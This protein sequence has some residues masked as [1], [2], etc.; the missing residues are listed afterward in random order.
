MVEMKKRGTKAFT[1]I[2][3]LV[4]IAIIA[5]LAAI[6]FPVFAQAKEAAKKTQ[7]LSNCKQMGTALAMYVS[8]YD[9][10][11]PTW[12]DYWALY[13]MV[14]A[15]WQNNNAAVLAAMG[16]AADSPAFYWDAKILPY[17]KSGAP[18]SGG[19]GGVWQSPAS[20]YQGKR[21]SY[22]ISQCFTYVCD[23][24]DARQYIWRN[25]N[26]IDNPANTPFVGESGW[27]GMMSFPRLFAHYNEVYKISPAN[28]DSDYYGREK[29]LRYGK[30]GLRDGV[31]PYV[32]CD[33]HAK[34]T[35]RAKL[36]Y[37]P[38]SG[39]AATAADLAQGRCWNVRWAVSASEKQNSATSATNAGF[40][41]TPDF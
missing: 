33:T 32:Y 15:P 14:G 2:E 9:D 35:P 27:S 26:D 20:P 38:T 4:V 37:F 12:S 25:G 1:L 17:V 31:A 6:L 40:P 3:L 39:T 7:S 24:T 36:Y 5:I 13:T 10:G 22:G 23:P 30:T 34:V 19:Y 16:V 18:Q 28:T 8:D 21:R 29:P 41:C 11:Y